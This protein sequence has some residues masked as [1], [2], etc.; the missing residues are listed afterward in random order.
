MYTAAMLHAAQQNGQ[1]ILLSC[2]KPTTW[3]YLFDTC[4]AIPDVTQIP[5]PL[6]WFAWLPDWMHIGQVTSLWVPD[7]VLCLPALP[8]LT[9]CLPSLGQKCP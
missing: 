2:Y 3:A 7:N 6:W 5:V 1:R 4:D 8:S 9:G